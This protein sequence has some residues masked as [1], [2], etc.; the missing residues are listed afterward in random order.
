MAANDFVKIILN[1]TT[2]M[3]VTDKTVTSSA[4]LNNYTAV[5]NS[6]TSITGNIATMTAGNLTASGSTVTAAAGYYASNTSKSVS[7]GTAGTPTAS[8]GTVSNHAVSITPSVTNTTGYITG[9]T[10]TG[11]AVSVSASELVSGTLAISSSGTADVTNYASVSVSVPSPNISSL[12]VTPSTSEQVFSG[13][14][15]VYTIPVNTVLY[16]GQDIKT[17][18]ATGSLSSVSLVEGQTYTVSGRVSSGSYYAE[19]S[20]S[21][22]FEY[23][24]TSSTS[25]LPYTN[26]FPTTSKNGITWVGFEYSAYWDTVALV[27]YYSSS[28]NSNTIVSTKIDFEGVLADGYLPVTVESMPVGSATT[29]AKTITANPT[30]SLNSSTGMVTAN[31]TGSS[32]VTP[33][34]SAGYVSSGTAGT[35]SVSGSS[36]YSLTTQAAQTITPGTQNITVASGRWL[37]GAQTV[38]GDANLVAANI[39]NG[40]TIFGVQGTHAGGTDT[41]DATATSADLLSGKTAYAKGVKLTGTIATMTAGNLTATWS[42]ITIPS[43]YYASAITKAVTAGTAGTPTASK[44]TASNNQISV[45]PSVTNTSG[46]IAGGTK[47]GTAV[48]VSASE[49]VGG[50]YIITG[51]GNSQ[52]VVN[53]AYVNVA[54]GAASV[55]ATTINPTLSASK[56][57]QLPG[58]I[59]VSASGSSS[60][61]PTITSGWVSTGTAGTVSVSSSNVVAVSAMDSAFVASNIKKDVSIFNIT[62]TYEGGSS[63]TVAPVGSII[64]TSTNNNPSITLGGTWTLIDKEFTSFHGVNSSLNGSSPSDFFVPYAANGFVLQESGTSSA[65]CYTSSTYPTNGCVVNRSG[66]TITVTLRTT[67]SSIAL[68]EDNKYIGEFN[69]SNLGLSAFT[70]TL[71]LL[72]WSETGNGIDMARVFQSSHTDGDHLVSTDVVVKT[73]SGTIAANSELLFTITINAN[74]DIMLDSACDK[75]YWK[76]TGATDLTSDPGILNPYAELVKTFSYDKLI[77]TDESITIPAYTTTATTLKAA[78]TSYGTYAAD[79]ANYDYFIVQEGLVTPVYNASGATIAAGRYVGWIGSYL[80]DYINMRPGFVSK[81]GLNNS[82]AS[83]TITASTYRMFYNN[84]ASILTS[85]NST[86]GCYMTFSTPTFGSTISVT[87]PA[88]MIRGSTSYFTSTYW[89]Y[90][91]DIR[92]Q[93][94]AKVYRIPKNNTPPGGYMLSELTRLANLLTN[95]STL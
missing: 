47:T 19:I 5:D 90:L 94:K 57:N 26:A 89:G 55:P 79:T 33:T 44:G 43:G 28:N 37:T 85:A 73:A 48:T 27:V 20:G 84:G 53:Y 39:A 80:H 71:H 41:S 17:R 60:I 82:Q 95:N 88:L 75:F 65:T 46:Y 10:K 15:L 61:T 74:K 9:G 1:G 76:K 72:G 67:S 14:G 29:P 50:T 34:V 77:V 62:G 2:L 40:V 64:C 87:C 92:Y 4:M 91:T 70:D 49:L 36:T 51:T 83:T 11:T 30:F 12:T 78:Q 45:T 23:V 86:Y 59:V 7:A 52:N 81:D 63:S 38:S 58:T 35:I 3:D 24:G 32:S 6:G 25:G 31:V 8:K 18:H 16:P 22:T 69:L 54:S 66:H 21:W 13:E 56:N 68:G 42:N 93:W